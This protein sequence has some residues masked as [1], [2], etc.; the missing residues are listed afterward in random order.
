MR[1]AV[2]TVIVTTFVL[3]TYWSTQVFASSSL[4]IQRYTHQGCV[5]SA[6][7]HYLPDYAQVGI[8]DTYWYSG[9]AEYVD[10]EYN[11]CR[12]VVQQ[13][14]DSCDLAVEYLGYLPSQE[15]ETCEAQ[16]RAEV[17]KC[18][19]HYNRQ[20]DACE[21]VRSSEST[22]SKAGAGKE[23]EPS[24]EE[25]LPSDTLSPGWEEL[26]PDELYDHA[27]FDRDLYGQKEKMDRGGGQESDFDKILQRYALELEEIRQEKLEREWEREA[28]KRVRD[29][30][31]EV[32]RLMQEH[33]EREERERL[34]GVQ[35]ESEADEGLSTVLQLL[36]AG[37]QIYN[38]YNQRSSSDAPYS[39]NSAPTYSSE[40]T[41]TRPKFTPLCNSADCRPDVSRPSH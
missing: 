14:Q 7:E 4:S 29:F 19:A 1:R 5:L 20:F 22:Q 10:F 35:R 11:N 23:E 24:W 39:T 31:E 28:E 12:D 27:A 9:D 34:A 33:R 37:A 25:L 15:R 21:T 16:Y 32:Q 13:A 40:R 36:G 38:M 8:R 3:T 26:L 18:R 41:E 6:N 2:L 30:E 17:P